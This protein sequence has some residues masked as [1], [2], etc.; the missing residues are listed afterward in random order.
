MINGC[1]RHR[2]DI[3]L[4]NEETLKRAIGFKSLEIHRKNAENLNRIIEILIPELHSKMDATLQSFELLAWNG[5]AKNILQNVEQLSQNIAGIDSA[6][7]GMMNVLGAHIMV[8][9]R[10]LEGLKEERKEFVCF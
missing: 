3:S 9:L 7:K 1:V 5:V 8:C 2:G 6:A 10:K 4:Y